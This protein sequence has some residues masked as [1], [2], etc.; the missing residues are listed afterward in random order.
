VDIAVIMVSYKT[1]PVLFPAID[2]VLKQPEVNELVI[3]DNGNPAEV[4]QQLLALAAAEPRVQLLRGQGNIGFAAASNLGAAASTA[5]RSTAAPPT[6]APPT[7][8][9]L[10]FLNPDCLLPAGC[11]GRMLHE[12]AALPLRS[13]LSPLLVNPDFTEQRGSRRSVLTPWRAVVEWLGLYRL[14]PRHPYF[15]RF[16]RASDPLPLHTHPVDVT[17]GAAM[18]IR[19]ELF[20]EL[21]GF[22]ENYFLHVE[23]VDLCVRLLKSG[24][25]AQVAPHI[26]V[27]HHLS[28]S[29]ISRVRVDWHKSVGFCRYFRKHF[30]GVYP[31]GFVAAVNLLVWCR[32]VIRLPL[33]LAQTVLV[34]RRTRFVAD[35]T[36]GG[37]S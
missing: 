3:V 5:A 18:L 22:D 16:N 26:R 8:A 4:G 29:D 35:V 21:G 30:E 13:L 12:L 19:R 15:R 17:S 33:Q 31:R 20:E 9:A 7:A 32:F 25:S 34:P 10:F 27:V 11:A 37:H 23:D 36:S 6:A 2:A 14:A 28:S 1:G 24:G